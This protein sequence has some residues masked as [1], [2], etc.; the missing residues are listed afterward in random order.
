MAIVTSRRLDMYHKEAVKP[1]HD[2]FP[3]EVETIDMASGEIRF[4]LADDG[5][6]ILANDDGVELSVS[7][8]IK[9]Q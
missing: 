1:L 5:G 6:E 7:K 2:A 9:W 3:N 8:F 4:L